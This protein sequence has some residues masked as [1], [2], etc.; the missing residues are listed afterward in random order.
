MK[1]TAFHDPD[2]PQCGNAVFVPFSFGILNGKEYPEPCPNVTA[3]CQ[4]CGGILVGRV[5]IDGEESLTLTLAVTEFVPAVNRDWAAAEADAERRR[6][7][8]AK[9]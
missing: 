9:L 2:C 4:N 8:T 7:A 1:S 5:L 3:F 6:T